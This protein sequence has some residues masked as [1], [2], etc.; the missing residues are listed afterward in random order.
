MVLPTK[1]I[2]PSHGKT[3]L[4]ETQSIQENGGGGEED[5]LRTL[6][7]GQLSDFTVGQ[8]VVG[9][10]L[11]KGE[12]ALGAQGDQQDVSHHCAVSV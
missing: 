6:I 3:E 5:F 7:S 10:S 2:E 9:L 8:L 1:G 4:L 12:R 11:G